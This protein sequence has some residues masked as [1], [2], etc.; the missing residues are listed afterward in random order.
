[1]SETKVPWYDK[2]NEEASDKPPFFRAQMAKFL[3]REV[4]FDRINEL[5]LAYDTKCEELFAARNAL[6]TEGMRADELQRFIDKLQKE[7]FANNG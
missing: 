3:S 7:D 1:M 4:V 2:S 5:L 6:L